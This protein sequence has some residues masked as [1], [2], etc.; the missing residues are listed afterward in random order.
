MS[1]LVYTYSDL[2]RGVLPIFLSD[3]YKQFHPEQY[4][5]EIVRQVSYMTPR[6]S[7]IPGQD[8]MLVWDIQGFVLHWLIYY[9]N[10]NF[11]SRSKESVLFE[12]EEYIKH[13]VGVKFIHSE[14]VAALHDL[15]HLPLMIRAVDEGEW[16]PMGCPMI[17]ISNTHPDFSWCVN[18]I[19]TLMSCETWHSMLIAGV[20]YQYRQI[21]NQ[22]YDVSVD[23]SV[24]RN[25]AISEF[26]LRGAESMESGTKTGAAFMTSFCTTATVPAIH[27]LANGLYCDEN[28]E[29]VGRGMAST[30]HSVMCSNATVDGN[31]YQTYERLLMDVYPTGNVSIVCDSYDYWNIVDEVLPALKNTILSRKGTLY[32]RGDSGDP[33]DIVVETVQH[34]YQ[35]FGGYVNSKGYLVLDDHIRVMYGDSITQQR[36]HEI[37]QRLEDLDFAAN[38]VGLGVGSFSMQCLEQDG[39]LYP[40][41]RD[42][43]SVAIKTTAAE[44]EDVTSGDT[45]FIEIFQDPKTDTGHFKK[46]QK[47]CCVVRRNEEGTL[48]YTDGHTWAEAFTDGENLLTPVFQDG[49]LMK[50]QS[51][52]EIRNRIHKGKF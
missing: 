2:G 5:K 47:G 10:E 38:N 45:Y 20:A 8:K 33:A 17:E 15:G 34:L 42:T 36:A 14:K 52:D 3:W 6:M 39:R 49:Y 31:E 23:D 13:H 48:G 22:Y 29:T 30:E 7:R 46:G 26:G 25:C 9:W 12:Y 35:T 27:Y 41:T 21:V 24:P 11:F 43:Y 37:Y 4:P 32:V 1:N 50:R 51:L 16:V 19:E 18:M 28:D 44:V 40:Y